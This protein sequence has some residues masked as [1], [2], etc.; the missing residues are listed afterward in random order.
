MS[1]KNEKVL[2]VLTHVDLFAGI[3][4]FSLAARWSGFRTVLAV[5]KDPYCQSVYKKHFPGVPLHSDIRNL[6]SE[7]I[8]NYTAGSPIDIIS[9][10]FPCQPYSV[11][12][13]RK[14][15]EDHRDLWPE[16]LRV[17]GLVNPR[18]IL[19]E[20]VPGLLDIDS[21]LVFESMCANMELLGYAIQPLFIPAAGAGAPHV[22]KRIIL[23][24][25]AD[26]QREDGHREERPKDLFAPDEGR[27]DTGKTG[28]Q[29]DGGSWWDIEPGM[30][31]MAYGV[32]RRLDRLRALG[33]SVVPRVAYGVFQAIVESEKVWAEWS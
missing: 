26:G 1:V 17:I 24:G 23:V 27:V 5:E 15:K 2:T 9:G 11:A 16:M 19:A 4:G 6:T 25:H 7:S 12:G 18:W 8:T 10:G 30:D 31:R 29:Y 14:G 22:R 33:N 32:P 3:G 20:N 21:G 28:K 13:K